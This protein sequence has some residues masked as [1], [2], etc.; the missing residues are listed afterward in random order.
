MEKKESRKKEN[1]LE[2]K[3]SEK[4]IKIG[5]FSIRIFGLIKFLLGVCLLPFVYSASISFLNEFGVIEKAM[6]NYF[7]SGLITLVIVYL[8]IWE[9]AII[10]TKGQK[11]LEI[12]FAFFKP[13]VRVA[14][15]LLPIYTLILFMAYWVL[16]FIWK[17]PNLVNYFLF[18]FGFTLGLHLIFSAKSIRSKQQDFLKANYIFGFSFIYIVNLI[19]I[20]LFFNLIFEKFSLVNFFNNSFQAAKNLFAVV[21]Q[22]LF[23]NQGGLR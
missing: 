10:Y 21:F 20:S 6:Q 4:P 18:L 9:P 11:I 1:N 2:A 15:Y 7:W 5:G 23:Y 17:S 8:F 22:Q 3:I 12:I 16:S 14:P 19:F 13:L